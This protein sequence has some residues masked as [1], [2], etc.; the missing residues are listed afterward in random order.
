MCKVT[1]QTQLYISI[2]SLHYILSLQVKSIFFTDVTN[3]YKQLQYMVYSMDTYGLFTSGTSTLYIL[4]RISLAKSKVAFQ[5]KIF[6]GEKTYKK[7][8]PLKE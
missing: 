4:E 6:K 7:Q 5:Q 3:L 8:K 2:E 1:L